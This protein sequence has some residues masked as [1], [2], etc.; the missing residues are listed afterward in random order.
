MFQA[1]PASDQSGAAGTSSS[2]TKKKGSKNKKKASGSSS[3]QDGTNDKGLQGADKPVA[4]VQMQP[5]HET[6]EK[7]GAAPPVHA[8]KKEGAGKAGRSGENV[9]PQTPADTRPAEVYGAD[10]CGCALF[11]V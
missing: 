9:K 2:K 4:T 10:Q 7:A 5:S 8:V 6:H 11:R 3:Q 1:L